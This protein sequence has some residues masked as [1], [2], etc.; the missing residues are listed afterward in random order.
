MCSTFPVQLGPRYV[1][2]GAPVPG[3][4]L[5]IHFPHNPQIV[6]KVEQ[7]QHRPKSD[8][9]SVNP[10][11]YLPGLSTFNNYEQYDPLPLGADSTFSLCS[12]YICEPLSLSV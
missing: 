8:C 12:S 10:I 3:P 6:A 11:A 7:Q 4:A 2:G 5:A 1:H 9:A